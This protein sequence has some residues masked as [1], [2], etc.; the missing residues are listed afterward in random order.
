VFNHSKRWPIYEDGDKIIIR[1]KEGEVVIL[2]NE[3]Q[4]VLISRI[5][6]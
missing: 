6:Q 4:I 1:I 5:Y 3:S 2:A